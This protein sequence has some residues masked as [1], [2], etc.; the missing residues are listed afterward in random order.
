MNSRDFTSIQPSPKEVLTTS[1]MGVSL[2]PSTTGSRSLEGLFA[3]VVRDTIV[4]FGHPALLTVSRRKPG[5]HLGSVSVTA[6]FDD[7]LPEEF[8][9]P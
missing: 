2:Y 3:S 1:G 7:P 5:L 4:F 8:W 9:A 6:D